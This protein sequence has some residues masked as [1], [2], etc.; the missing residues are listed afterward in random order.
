MAAL[1][2][3]GATGVALILRVGIVGQR[4]VLSDLTASDSTCIDLARAAIDRIA[5]SPL[6]G[7]AFRPY[8]DQLVGGRTA[9]F[10][11]LFPTQPVLRLRH[12]RRDSRCAASVVILAVSLWRC[13]VGLR[14]RNLAPSSLAGARRPGRNRRGVFRELYITQTWTGSVVL[15]VAATAS[16]TCASATGTEDETIDPGLPAR[17]P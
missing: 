7:D 4:G 14:R 2:A 1:G 17:S 5:A 13:V 8:S 11:R 3:I 12:Q 15:I 16:L 9:D 10:A 6:V